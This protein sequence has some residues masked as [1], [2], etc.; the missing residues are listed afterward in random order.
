MVRG[1]GGSAGD[2]MDATDIGCL[3]YCSATVKSDSAYAAREVGVADKG[4]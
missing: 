3:G 1:D 2:K 4:G